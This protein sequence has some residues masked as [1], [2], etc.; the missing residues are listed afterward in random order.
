M[1]LTD[2]QTSVLARVGVQLLHFQAVENLL[3]LCTQIVL[4]SVPI[5][6]LVDL[7][8]LEARERKKTLGY[9][10]AALRSRAK[11]EPGLDDALSRFLEDRNTFVHNIDGFAGWNLR[12]AEGCA[13]CVQILDSIGTRTEFVMGVFTGLLR[14]WE[15]QNGKPVVI[16]GYEAEFR[17]IEEELVPLV[18]TFFA[19]KSDA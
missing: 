15:L 18:D 6:K 5:E 8:A 3:R 2:H 13:A 1:T 14:A 10:M 19:P 16:P 11:V 17:R 9:F 7:H 12:S 4:P